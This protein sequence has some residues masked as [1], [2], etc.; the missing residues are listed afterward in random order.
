MASTSQ[1]N[2]TENNDK[3]DNTEESNIRATLEGIDNPAFSKSTAA[4][5][6][7]TKKIDNPLLDHT[8]TAITKDTNG[9][10]NPVSDKN[11]CVS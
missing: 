8:M 5:A 1:A 11:R 4:V 2:L 10:K 3:T 7:D 6:R 9:I